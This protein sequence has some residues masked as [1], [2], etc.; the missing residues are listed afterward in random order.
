MAHIQRDPQS[1]R[2][3]IRFRYEGVEYNRSLKTT[4][5]RETV[6]ILGQ[7]DEMIRLLDR[8]RLVL[9]DHADPAC[10]IISNG[11]RSSTPA[12]PT[13]RTVAGLFHCYYE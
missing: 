11:N 12:R 6:V 3:R 10:F 8:G 1:R 5:H 7:V 2:F 13:V 4:S 9:P